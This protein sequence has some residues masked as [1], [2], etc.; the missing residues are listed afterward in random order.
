MV[1]IQ[2]PW[3]CSQG[4][5]APQ[6]GSCPAFYQAPALVRLLVQTYLSAS[7][8]SLGSAS[9]SWCTDMPRPPSSDVG[10]KVFYGLFATLLSQHKGPVPAHIPVRIVPAV[11]QIIGEFTSCFFSIILHNFLPL[12]IVI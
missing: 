1:Q 11:V 2:A 7:P 12:I 9:R 6:L 10:A 8:R 3:N 5:P 4:C